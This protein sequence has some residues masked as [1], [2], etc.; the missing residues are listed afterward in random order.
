MADERLVGGWQREYNKAMDRRIRSWAM[1]VLVIAIN[2]VLVAAI[3]A[4]I[5]ATWLPALI[6]PHPNAPTR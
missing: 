1:R 3:L 2:V 5:A 6:G 4:I